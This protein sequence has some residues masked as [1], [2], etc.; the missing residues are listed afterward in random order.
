MA[1]ITCNF[2]SYS[3]RRA[4]DITVIIPT[5]TIPSISCAARAGIPNT[6]A[7]KA[8]Y[9]VL[10][11]LHGMG[12]NHATWNGYSNIELYAEERQIAV[13]CPS[14]E[15][16]GY[17]PDGRDDFFQFIAEELPDF[18]CGMFPISKRPEDTYVAGLSMGGYGALVHGLSHPERFAAV[19]A[20]SAGAAIPPAELVNDPQKLLKAVEDGSI[21]NQN[22][23]IPIKYDV[24]ALTAAA[25]FLSA[26]KRTS[27]KFYL[28]CGDM[29]SVYERAVS[30]RDFLCSVGADVT[31][32]E[33]HG[34]EHEW[35]FWD[36][37]VE[38]FLDWI[39]RTD[40]YN[41]EA[42]RRV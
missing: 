32:D 9:P 30:Y 12:N 5:P 38:R 21:L 15:N 20:F 13:V 27:P 34:Y 14:G 41:K 8:P 6:H 22:S 1:K 25:R 42:R 33:L 2:V 29:D 24:S 31:W 19:G 17:I 16:K 7:P 11:L 26:E 18:I 3:L 36:I 35:R 37:E 4:V 10:Y 40:I 39:P 28:A 23:P